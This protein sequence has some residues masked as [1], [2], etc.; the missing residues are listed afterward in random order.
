MTQTTEGTGAGAVS[1]VYAPLYNSVVK[2]V[3]LSENLLN[4]LMKVKLGNDW[5]ITSDSTINEVSPETEIF[6]GDGD[7]EFIEAEIGFPIR[8]AGN[9]YSTL[10]V[11]SNSYITFGQGGD[12][13]DY[14]SYEEWADYRPGLFI[15][16]DDN[17]YQVILTN[18]TVG[19]L[20]NRTTTI[21]FQGSRDTS[22]NSNI[23]IVWEVTFYEAN[24]DRISLNVL[25]YAKDGE[26]EGGDF[27][28]LIT[29]GQGNY[30][31]FQV[32]NLPKLHFDYKTIGQGD[33]IDFT[34]GFIDVSK[35]GN[36]IL[37]DTSNYKRLPQKNIGSNNYMLALSDAG[38]HIYCADCT[39]TVPYHAD[40]PFPIGTKIT[41]V[42]QGLGIL[43]NKDGGSTAIFA[44][45]SDNNAYD[46][47][48]RSVV[49]LLKTDMEVWY[50]YGENITVD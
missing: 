6:N 50:L 13:Y 8:F 19:D 28:S 15:G 32:E 5:V 7:D 46:I 49:H 16:V 23:P 20:G 47:G 31:T 18:S 9:D 41:I 1:N 22:E 43:L 21:R 38:K 34:D 3:N 44:A 25:A 39:I 12:E 35:D 29:D 37:V 30:R 48:A 42:T 2:Q 40:V 24:P 10:F 14:E 11:G 45:G 26:T 27:Y 36:S 4:N 33:S 17:S